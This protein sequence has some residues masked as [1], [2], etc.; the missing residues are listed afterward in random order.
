MIDILLNCTYL[1]KESLF[2]YTRNEAWKLICSIIA[3]FN[4]KSNFPF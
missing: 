4:A 3:F 1:E 2:V